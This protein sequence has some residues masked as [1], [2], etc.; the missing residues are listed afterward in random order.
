MRTIE[1]TVRMKNE[2]RGEGQEESEE[3]TAEKDGSKEGTNWGQKETWRLLDVNQS[4]NRKPLSTN[5]STGYVFMPHLCVCV[6][7]Y[8]C[9]CVCAVRDV[10]TNLCLLIKNDKEAE[11]RVAL[12]RP[13]RHCHFVLPTK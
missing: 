7:V 11:A 3:K 10:G 9:V 13:T 6:C 1:I 5:S 2:L 12:K 4:S 8:V